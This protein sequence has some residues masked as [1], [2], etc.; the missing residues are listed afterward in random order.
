MYSICYGD[1]IIRYSII[2]KARLKHIYIEVDR[3]GV[4]VKANSRVKIR[5]IETLVM[6]KANWI[7]KHL[8]SFKNRN[9]ESSIQTGSRI[10][11]LGKSYYTKVLKENRDDIEIKF[12]YSKFII[13]T[14]KNL[15][16]DMI[17]KQLDIFY[18]DKALEKIIPL[19]DRYS[20][21]MNLTPSRITF[22][23]AKK[24][25]GSCSYK[26]SIS[27]NYHLMKLPLSCI[28]YVVVHEL[29]H[30]KHKNHSNDFWTLVGKYIPEYKEIKSRIKEFEKIL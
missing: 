16:N 6:K 18:K 10:Y 30:I 4:I 5:D 11:Y 29:S 17:Y 13:K 7:L 19:V 2:R 1:K 24:R 14:P 20:K 3:D 8:H 12:A 21:E 9:K 15:S 23:K 28:R 22:R 25:W 26:N 27:L